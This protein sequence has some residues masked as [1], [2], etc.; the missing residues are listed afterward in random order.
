[1]RLVYRILSSNFRR[2]EIG[3]FRGE[4]DNIVGIYSSPSRIRHFCSHSVDRN[5]LI[6]I[7]ANHGNPE[8]D[9]AR[10]YRVRYSKTKRFGRISPISSGNVIVSVCV[11]ICVLYYDVPLSTK[12]AVFRRFGG[13]DGFSHK[14][15]VLSRFP[16][17]LTKHRCDRHTHLFSILI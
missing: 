9:G 6:P 5:K 16:S 10:S 13:L 11:C 1:M 3:S 7:M 2:T 14:Y 15:C 4:R 17:V 8:K 12:V